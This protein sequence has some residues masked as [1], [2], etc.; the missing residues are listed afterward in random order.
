MEFVNAAVLTARGHQTM[1]SFTSNN[2][3]S[4]VIHGDTWNKLEMRMEQVRDHWF[5]S[6]CWS[7]PLIELDAIARICSLY[8]C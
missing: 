8:L 1:A 6:E 3:Q 2:S 7:G 5:E 4:L